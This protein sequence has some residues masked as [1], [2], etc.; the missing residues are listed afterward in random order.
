MR[1]FPGNYMEFHV[2]NYVCE[3]K[4]TFPTPCT[5]TLLTSA[6]LRSTSYRA[7]LIGLTLNTNYLVII[8]PI[9]LSLIIFYSAFYNEPKN[10]KM[11]F[12]N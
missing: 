3:Y 1:L 10:I 12:K 2:H 4:F 9:N 8:I 5:H 11:Y 7:H 6:H